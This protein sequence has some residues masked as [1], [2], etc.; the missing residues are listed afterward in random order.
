MQDNPREEKND[1]IEGS[2]S[3]NMLTLENPPNTVNKQASELKN[4]Y[5][6]S[7]GML[8]SSLE[9]EQISDMTIGNRFDVNQD[10]EVSH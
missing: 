2:D 3:F 10:N 6:G 4:T 9:M 7:I 8:G 5:S 1:Q